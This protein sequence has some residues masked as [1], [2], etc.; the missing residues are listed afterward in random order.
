MNYHVLLVWVHHYILKEVFKYINKH[1]YCIHCQLSI[2]STKVHTKNYNELTSLIC[3]KTYIITL[4]II[5]VFLW[6]L[7]D[8]FYIWTQQYAIKY[9]LFIGRTFSLHYLI[10]HEIL[11]HLSD[12]LAA[13]LN[14]S[15][16]K[17]CTV[18]RSIII[19]DIYWKKLVCHY[20]C[21]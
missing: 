16:K 19:Y 10:H 6:R 5:C 2:Y 3:T 4:H 21:L 14:K 8:T 20:K 11:K 1:A 12:K 7:T 15:C 9:P 18:F 13:Y 17:K